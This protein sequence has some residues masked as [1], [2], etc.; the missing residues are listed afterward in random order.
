MIVLLFLTTV[1]ALAAI[2][3][4]FVRHKSEQSSGSEPIVDFWDQES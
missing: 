2:T 4:A 1:I 3:E